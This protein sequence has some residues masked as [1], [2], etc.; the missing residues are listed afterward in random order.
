MR[1]SYCPAYRVFLPTPSQAL[2]LY[3]SQEMQVQPE[4]DTSELTPAAAAH[5]VT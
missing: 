2:R 1:T 5:Q 3:S 4:E